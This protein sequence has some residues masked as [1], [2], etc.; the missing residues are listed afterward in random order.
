MLQNLRQSA[1][2]YH[3]DN[4][5]DDMLGNIPKFYGLSLLLSVK[6]IFEHTFKALPKLPQQFRS[7]FESQL[8]CKWEP[9]FVPE[10]PHQGKCLPYVS[11]GVSQDGVI[12]GNR[13]ISASGQTWSQYNHF[14]NSQ[15]QEYNSKNCN[16]NVFPRS[17]HH[18]M[19]SPS[20][21]LG[22]QGKNGDTFSF[23]HNPIPKFN[24][25][26][27]IELISA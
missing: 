13:R 16:R 10:I 8:Q 5:V 21:P 15:L 19:S 18:F 6:Y 14:I 22:S 9:I 27:Q 12:A 11:C 2:I 3:K 23:C 7:H 25:M 1:I 24:Y 26:T 4:E 20:F 17:P